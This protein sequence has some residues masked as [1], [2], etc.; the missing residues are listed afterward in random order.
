MPSKPPSKSRTTPIICGS[1]SETAGERKGCREGSNGVFVTDGTVIYSVDKSG[2]AQTT[3]TL[4]DVIVEP[5]EIATGK[6]TLLPI[7]GS[8]AAWGSDTNVFF[9]R[10][11]NTLWSYEIG[12]SQATRIVALPGESNP[13]YASEPLLSTDKTWLA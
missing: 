10:G 5:I 9:V 6:E 4:A 3:A 11:S 1:G 2:K 7:E 12:A 8:M 13:G